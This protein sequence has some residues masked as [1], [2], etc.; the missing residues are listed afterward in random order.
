MWWHE[1]SCIYNVQLGLYC[2]LGELRSGATVLLHMV[3]MFLG[4][5]GRESNATSYLM[6]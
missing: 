4:K 5:W 6:R 1:A 3:G 2:M